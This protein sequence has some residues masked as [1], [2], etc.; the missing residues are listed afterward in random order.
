MDI[1]IIHLKVGVDLSLEETIKSYANLDEGN[2]RDK[3][4][5]LELESE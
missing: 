2:G 5:K 1:Y 3:I 4:L